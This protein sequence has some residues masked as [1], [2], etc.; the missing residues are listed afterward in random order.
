MDTMEAFFLKSGHFSWFSKT[1]KAGLPY[2]P[3]SCAPVSVSE[4]VSISLNI[5]QYPWKSS[6]M[7]GRLLNMPRA[8]NIGFELWHGCI[9]KGYTDFW[10][11]LNMTHRLQNS[12]AKYVGNKKLRRFQNFS[13]CLGNTS[14]KKLPMTQQKPL[15]ITAA[16]A[17]R[18]LCDQNIAAL[19]NL[20]N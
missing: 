17:L 1:G 2:S 13:V 15:F 6:Y 5:P 18:Y 9:Y 19:E 10:I 14:A 7:F 20:G 16:M 12:V 3:P 4:Y 8:L 11:C